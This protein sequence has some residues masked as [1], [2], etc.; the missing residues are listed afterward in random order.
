MKYNLKYILKR[1]V[2]LVWDFHQMVEWLVRYIYICIFFFS[3]LYFDI[4]IGSDI[5]IGWFKDNKA[6]LKDCHATGRTSP[7]VDKSQDY[8]LLGGAEVD[9]Y[10]ILKFKRKLITCDQANDMNI[11]VISLILWTQTW[12]KYY[13]W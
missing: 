1:L 3:Y 9:G 10:T 2:G 7:I 8:V 6:Y 5:V 13:L 4:W 11:K 12:L